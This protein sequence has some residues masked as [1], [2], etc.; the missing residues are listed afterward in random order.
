MKN[1]GNV[2]LT[3]DLKKQR[4][5]IH[6][7]T[8]RQLGYPDYVQLLVNPEQKT[9]ILRACEESACQA[10]KVILE[11]N[12]DCE[13]YSKEVLRRLKTVDSNL[14]GD[15]SFLIAGKTDPSRRLAIFRMEDIH[16][17]EQVQSQ[18]NCKKGATT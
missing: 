8:L 7:E 16:P 6:K 1:Q 15:T 12:V 14:K 2:A 3:L 11:K 9:I 4:M 5:R 17:L 18:N 10:H 13:L